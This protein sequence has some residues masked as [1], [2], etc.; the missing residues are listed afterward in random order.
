MKTINEIDLSPWRARCKEVDKAGAFACEVRYVE[1]V[2]GYT[3]LEVR[4]LGRTYS[5]GN[6]SMLSPIVC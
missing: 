2:L 5:R 1:N 6:T 3:V 4:Q